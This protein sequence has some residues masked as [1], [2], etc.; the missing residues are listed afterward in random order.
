MLLFMRKLSYHLPA[1]HGVPGCSRVDVPLS[2]VNGMVPGTLLKDTSAGQWR[3][4][5]EPFLFFTWV[6]PCEVVVR[7]WGAQAS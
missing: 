2:G 1:P 6:L 3:R 5:A 4:M 7:S